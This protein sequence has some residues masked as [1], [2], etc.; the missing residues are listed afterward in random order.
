MEHLDL[1]QKIPEP[2]LAWYGGQARS[3]PWRDN[4]EP[5]GVGV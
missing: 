5:P 2:L 1:L 4:P 3:L